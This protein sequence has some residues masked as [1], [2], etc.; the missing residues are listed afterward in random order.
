MP[1]FSRAELEEALRI[2]NAA[3]DRACRTGDW[4]VWAELFTDDAEYVEHAF[5][6]FHGRE[7]IRDWITK[8]M[9]PFPDMTFPQDWV[10]FDEERG[11]IVFQCQNR[12]EHP[13]DPDG[14]PFQFPNW[15][16]LVYAGGGRFSSEEDVYNPARDAGKTIGAWLAAGGRLASEPTVDMAH[17][18]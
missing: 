16:R 9:A 2:Y 3:R 11:A 10:V 7:Q 13:T 14:E 1:R 12:L 17:G 6:T 8:V 18:G 15:T 4:N 5:G